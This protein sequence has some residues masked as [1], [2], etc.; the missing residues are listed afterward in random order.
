MHK[1][2]HL[3]RTGTKPIDENPLH[4]YTDVTYC[5]PFRHIYTKIFMDITLTFRHYTGLQICRS[6]TKINFSLRFV[7]NFFFLTK[8]GYNLTDVRFQGVK[9]LRIAHINSILYVTPQQ[10]IQRRRIAWCWR[11]N[12]LIVKIHVREVLQT[13][14]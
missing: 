14:H 12:H 2:I 8:L 10:I 1:F 4:T 6:E 9:V 7:S 5:K 11:P 13:L 3:W